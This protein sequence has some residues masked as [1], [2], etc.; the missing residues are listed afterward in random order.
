MADAPTKKTAPAAKKASSAR[1]TAEEQAAMK[2]YAQERKAAAGRGGKTTKADGEADVQAAFDKM[3]PDDRALGEAVHALVAAHAPELTPK[4]YY[5]MPA[6]AKDDKV[7][8]WFK[9][10]SKFKTRYA[11][12]GFSDK[13]ALD[14]GE[15]WAT[16]YAVTSWTPAVEKKVASL[17]KK[18]IG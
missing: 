9:N 13:A 11:T 16:E 1:V 15:L 2:A 5:G 18:A 10:A 7:V 6:Y 8:F 3:P 17:I 14:D 4:T 12:I